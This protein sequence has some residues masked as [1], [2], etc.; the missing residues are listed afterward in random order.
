MLRI[1]WELYA[2]Q[3][4]ARKTLSKQNLKKSYI[5]EIPLKCASEQ[6]QTLKDLVKFIEK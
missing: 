3:H 6:Q 5:N 2:A 4:S 1:R